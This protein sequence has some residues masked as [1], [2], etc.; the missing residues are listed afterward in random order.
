MQTRLKNHITKPNKRYAL[1]AAKPN[2]IDIEPR[3]HHQ[4]LKEKHWR[5]SMSKEYDSQIALRTWD[6]VPPSPSQN[7]IDTKWIY[8]IKLL[9]DGMLDKYK[10]RFVARG[11]KRHG[12]RSSLG[13]LR[14]THIS[15]HDQL[16]D[17]LTKPLT[18]SQFTATRH[19]IGVSQALPS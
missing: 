13:Q 5:D 10:S 3:T 19:K 15:T 6:L 1:T 9:A 16:A 8:R 18:R 7:V 14:I 12:F 11:F 17:G 2:F 4:A